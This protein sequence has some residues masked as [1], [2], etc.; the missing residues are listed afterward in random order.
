MP[1]RPG[2]EAESGSGDASAVGELGNFA[3]GPTAAII[4]S[5][6]SSWGCSDEL[7]EPV[8]RAGHGD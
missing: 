5:A 6:S 4:P 2:R 8:S 3:R 7:L 1:R